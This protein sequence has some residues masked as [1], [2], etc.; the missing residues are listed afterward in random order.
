MPT[1]PVLLLDAQEW[2]DSWPSPSGLTN[3]KTALELMESS[4]SHSHCDSVYLFSDGSVSDPNG[5]IQWVEDWAA[6]RGK[7]P[8][9]HCV[10]FFPVGTDGGAG[11]RFLK[12]LAAMTGGTYRVW[13]ILFTV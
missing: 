11:A 7:L 3:L 4:D 9:F 6:R 1:S 12:E 2:V 13:A 10:G 8:P 5:T